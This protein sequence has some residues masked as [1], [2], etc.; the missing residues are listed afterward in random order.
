MTIYLDCVV[1][2][3]PSV[4][5]TGTVIADVI[6]YGKIDGAILP[7]VLVDMLCMEP[8][9]L[10]AV[11][12]LKYIHF[13]GAP[14]STKSGNLLKDFVHLVPSIGSTETG[15]YFTKIS[16]KDDAAYTEWDYVEF[17]EHA[18]AHFRPY[19]NDLHELVFIKD[20][21]Y[22]IQPIFELYPKLSMYETKDLW[23]RHPMFPNHWKIIGRVDDYIC[24]AH[25]EGL[26]AAKIE[27]SIAENPMIKAALI[28][29]QGSPWPIL[30]IETETDQDQWR[31]EQTEKFH[32]VL[33]RQIQEINSSLHE[34]VQLNTNH[35]IIAKQGKPFSRTEKGSIGRYQTLRL[36][37]AEI[38]STYFQRKLINE[39]ID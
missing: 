15:G 29:A 22:M 18:G 7:P 19:S 37:E 24:F 34:K 9:G 12:S 36:Y 38:C 14:L 26:H 6:T 25:G 4:P 35:L 39:G 2:N 30:L 27:Q 20:P 10:A 3:G 16:T 28:G 23:M 1:V 5:L 17:Q 13:V 21:A 33:H 32:S 8:Q 31:Q 11:R